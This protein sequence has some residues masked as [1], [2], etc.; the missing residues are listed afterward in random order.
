M[1]AIS[2]DK[3]FKLKIEEAI[4]T[5]TEPWAPVEIGWFNEQVIR[6]ALYR[7]EYHWHTHQ[8]D[9]A[10]LVHSGEL[11]IQLRDQEDIVLKA[12]EMG[13]VSRGIEHCPKSDEDTY[14]L[15]IEPGTLQSEGDE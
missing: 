9:E 15:M 8:E 4:D 6:L 1:Y 13:I 2:M 12:G 3:A 14:A 11:T 10:F 5:I 7:G